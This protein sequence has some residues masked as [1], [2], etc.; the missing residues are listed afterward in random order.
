MP[1][2]T[3]SKR[4]YAGIRARDSRPTPRRE[5]LMAREEITTQKGYVLWEAS[6][7]LQK[8]IRR[9]DEDAAL[10]WATELDKSGYGE[11]VFK[12][13]KIIASEDIGLGE[14]RCSL[15]VESL[16]R[17]WVDQR[18]KKDG[19]N[20]EAL[21]LVHAVLLCVR[22]KK[23]RMVDHACCVYYNNANDRR[24]VPDFALDKH[25]LRGKKMG[26][27]FEHFFSAGAKLENT[28]NLEDLYEARAKEILLN[29]AGQ[30]TDGRD[31]EDEEH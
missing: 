16:H 11:Y 19:T 25:T 20:S 9:G 23:S 30:T 15:L 7:A 26:R 24:E 14:V 18:K 13:L 21:F 3:N 4:V 22:A 29:R 6:S 5:A 10:F 28:S 2:L 31:E 8:A 12:R 17:N 27:G 1:R